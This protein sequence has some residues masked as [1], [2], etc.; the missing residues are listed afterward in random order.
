MA[1]V[2]LKRHTAHTPVENTIYADD[3]FSGFITEECQ[4]FENR[5]RIIEWLSKWI[6]VK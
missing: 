3:V 1:L 2:H 6:Y 5:S 4:E